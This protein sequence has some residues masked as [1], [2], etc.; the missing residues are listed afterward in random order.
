MP[1]QV[2]ESKFQLLW[3]RRHAWIACR[4]CERLSALR[5]LYLRGRRRHRFSGRRSAPQRTAASVPRLY[6]HRTISW[7]RQSHPSVARVDPSQQICPVCTVNSSLTMHSSV[8]VPTSLCSCSVRM[9]VWAC[10]WLCRWGTWCTVHTGAHHTH[11]LLEVFLGM[12]DMRT[13]QLLT[14]TSDKVYK[15]TLMST[16]NIFWIG[17]TYLKVSSV[18]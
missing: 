14:G 11:S 7:Y 4:P 6:Y 15:S 1:N 12:W 16:I 8:L 13:N 2:P 18:V 17:T 5:A 10:L 3:W 9:S